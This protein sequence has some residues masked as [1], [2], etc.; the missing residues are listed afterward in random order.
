MDGKTIS[1]I[2]RERHVNRALTLGPEDFI[3]FQLS[4]PPP[5]PADFERIKQANLGFNDSRSQDALDQI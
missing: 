4:S 3:R 1:T 2:G 5:L